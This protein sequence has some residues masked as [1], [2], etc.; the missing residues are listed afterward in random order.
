V[1]DEQALIATLLVPLA[2]ALLVAAARGRPNVREGASLLVGAAL[3]VLVGRLAAALRAGVPPSVQIAEPVEGLRLAF[4]VEPLGLLF[5]AVA[6]LLWPVTTLYAIGYMRSHAERHQ[7]RF[8][9]CFAISIAAVTGIAFSANLATLFVCYEA[10]SLATFPLVTHANNGP[11]WRAGRIYLGILMG[12]SIAFFLPAVIAVQVLAGT[13]DFQAG[14]VLR[15]AFAS[16]R[17][18]EGGLALILTLFVFGAAKAAVMPLHRWLPNAMVAP[19]PVSAL[20]H[21]VAVVKAGVFTI[22]KVVVAIFGAD[23][24]REIDFHLV[25]AHFVA[26][27]V[28][29]ASVIA[30]GK[31]NLKERLAYSTIGQLAYIVLGALVA[32]PRAI[33]GAGVHL[34]AHACGKITLFFAAGAFL[35]TAH[36]SRVSQLDGIARRMPVTMAC[37]LVGALCIVGLPP[38]G[39]MWSKFLLIDGMA[40]SEHWWLLGALLV[41]SLLNVVYLLAVPFRAFVMPEVPAH[42]DYANHGAAPLMCRVAMVVSASLTVLLFLFPDEVHALVQSSLRP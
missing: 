21:A 26:F 18:S 34:A 15:E 40:R 14:G 33:E 20:L 36:K 25:L 2:G 10:L 37:F 28:V 19:T 41:S 7:T 5:A 11:A 1:T 35:V 32:T 16:G 30:L 12:A 13:T 3:L 29:A 6:A 27:T 39:G 17:V 9:V 31:D 42:G 38:T 8:F 24:V 23:L 4:A 22:L